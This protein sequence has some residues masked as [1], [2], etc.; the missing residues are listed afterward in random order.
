MG[1]PWVGDRS[2]SIVCFVLIF[3]PVAFAIIHEL[4]FWAR[5]SGDP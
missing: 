1:S 2:G 3:G 5:S 4:L